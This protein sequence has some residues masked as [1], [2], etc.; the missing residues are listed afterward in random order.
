MSPGEFKKLGGGV[1]GRLEL[2]RKFICFGSGRRP[3]FPSFLHFLLCPRSERQ[4]WQL[5]GET[6]KRIDSRKG[7]PVPPIHYNLSFTPLSY[8]SGGLEPSLQNLIDATLHP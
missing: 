4:E 3:L 2:F 6:F 8:I 1:E 5:M 7:R